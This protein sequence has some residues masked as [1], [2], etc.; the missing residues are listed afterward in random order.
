MVPPVCTWV[1]GCSLAVEAWRPED[2]KGGVT[3]R[4]KREEERKKKR[5][6]DGRGKGR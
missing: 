6:R 4:G 1:C 2:L 3:E 5:K